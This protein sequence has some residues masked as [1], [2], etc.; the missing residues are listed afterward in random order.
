M[1][2][3]IKYLETI[4]GPGF[5]RRPK[6]CGTVYLWV[7]CAKYGRANSVIGVSDGKSKNVALGRVAGSAIRPTHSGKLTDA[8]INVNRQFGNES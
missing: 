3:V 5:L 4:R 1:R 6:R 8:N 7:I 2:W